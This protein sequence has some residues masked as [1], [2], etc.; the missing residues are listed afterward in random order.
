M[1]LVTKLCLSAGPG[2]L[3]LLSGAARGAGSDGTLSGIVPV[4][5]QPR[6][7]AGTV[8]IT[9]AY[10]S[11]A[12]P[13][14]DVPFGWAVAMD[15]GELVS[16]VEIDGGRVT[17]HPVNR[18]FWFG[19][20]TMAFV[21]DGPKHS[22]SFPK[23]ANTILYPN[24]VGRILLSPAT[25]DEALVLG[26]PS[27]SGA[28]VVSNRCLRTL[29]AV[30]SVAYTDYFG[31]T[32][33]EESKTVVVG[34]GDCVAVSFTPPGRYWRAAYR[35][36]SCGW[37]SYPYLD[38]PDRNR[39]FVAREDVLPLEGTFPALFDPMK[40][41]VRSKVF[42]FSARIPIGWKGGRILLGV[43]CVHFR[44]DFRVNG[45]EAGTLFLWETPAKLDV[46]RFAVPGENLTVEVTVTDASVCAAPHWEPGKPGMPPNGVRALAAA[47]GHYPRGAISGLK[48]R[49]VLLAEPCLR[50]DNVFV[51]P[52]L[53][54]NG[55]KSLSC[56]F[57]FVNDTSAA[58]T[59]DVACDILL[60]GRTIAALPSF[61]LGIKAGETVRRTVTFPAADLDF[62]TPETPVLYTLRTRLAGDV[63]RARF[64]FRTLGIDGRHFTLNGKPVRF[65]GFSQIY[66][67]ERTWP[68]A[69]LPANFARWS[70]HDD[71]YKMGGAGYAHLADELGIFVKGENMA[72]NSHHNDRY[73]Y[74]RETIWERLLSEHRQAIRALGNCPSIAFWDIG[75]ENFLSKPGEPERCGRLMDEIRA[76]DP[77]RL[78]TI[79][80]CLPRPVGPGVLDLDTHGHVTMQGDAEFVAAESRPWIF[81]ESMYM[82]AHLLPGLCGD[83]AYVLPEK[84]GRYAKVPQ[85]LGRR[86]MIRAGKRTD[87][88]ATLGH[89]AF[90]HGREISPVAAFT[91]D[92]RLRF[93]SGER[94]VLTYEAYNHVSHD[95]ELIV[96]LEL[97]EKGCR[98]GRL[99]RTVSV[100]PYGRETVAFD[101]G[102]MTADRDRRLDLLIDVEARGGAVYRDY[103][104]VSVYAPFVARV[105]EGVRLFVHDPAGSAADWLSRNGVSFTRVKSADGWK[106]DADA[107]LLVIGGASVPAFSD[108]AP[109]ILSEDSMGVVPR[110]DLAKSFSS[111]DLRFWCDS[112]GPRRV[113][114][115]VMTLP[116][117]GNFRILASGAYRDGIKAQTTPL[118]ECASGEGTVRYCRMD[119]FG[120]DTVDPAA[121]RL[122]AW[123][124]SNPPRRFVS[125]KTAALVSPRVRRS[126]SARGAEGFVASFGELDLASTK[127]LVTDGEAMSALTEGE[128]GRLSAW[129]GDG[130]RMFVL[131]AEPGEPF[132]LDR[133]RFVREDPLLDGVSVG[134]LFWFAGKTGTNRSIPVVDETVS[135]KGD[136]V[137]ARNLVRLGEPLVKPAYLTR[138]DVGAGCVYRTTLDFLSSAQPEAE[139]LLSS[140]LTNFGVKLSGA[141]ATMS[142]VAVSYDQ[143]KMLPLGDILPGMKAKD[144][145]TRVEWGD[146]G[147][148][149]ARNGSIPLVYRREDG[150]PLV[151]S[152]RWFVQ[153]RTDVDGKPH[154]RG[155]EYAPPA[156]VLTADGGTLTVRVRGVWIDSAETVTLRP[157][158]FTVR[159]AFTALKSPDEGAKINFVQPAT[160]LGG[161]EWRGNTTNVRPLIASWNDMQVSLGYNPTYRWHTGYAT[162]KK[163]SFSISPFA[164]RGKRFAAG[165]KAE[166]VLDFDFR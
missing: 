161:A 26:P 18:A 34:A 42:S 118:Y 124:V 89:V 5:R 25:I 16:S 120:G 135:Q 92:G 112:R 109:E 138:E 75:N 149:I 79:S 151:Q 95:D 160:F 37:E 23:P 58:R 6:Q 73:D 21:P 22:L 76:I 86:H 105:P 12:V 133:A 85:I 68:A 53:G 36:R 148:V 39:W 44:A 140:L 61:A 82:H 31:E 40:E 132:A 43:P 144:V 10:S 143:D 157:D 54:P 107:T 134:D 65:W 80:G 9:D 30:V 81:S 136:D 98:V 74:G 55:E 62:W 119:F 101:F 103:E 77:T 117:R 162:G 46:T 45:Q 63:H 20:E 50:T 88:A 57:T 115:G 129:L 14:A 51:R 7:I 35:L 141:G 99:S 116:T 1:I 96:T 152:S 139:R 2:L 106:G 150:R 87:I 24:G 154:H 64:G 102:T 83:E 59:E 146:Y 127:R 164:E 78:V 121:E 94:V 84:V 114:A 125:E 52:Q 69:P 91:K 158:G 97:R 142:A 100:G 47:V 153:E 156:G 41:G 108:S 131:N 19:A 67:P 15:A 66:V 111:R 110:G 122:L 165:E 70:F 4:A 104:Q 38:Y 13:Q 166:A 71:A 28:L 145:L 27:E 11:F 163:G 49:L 128:R 48:S 137:I 130:G 33:A 60:N 17:Q 113:A 32:L 90:Y 72:H 8:D 159:Y 155:L 126:L 123:L 147:M 29:E 93:R 56:D 3:C